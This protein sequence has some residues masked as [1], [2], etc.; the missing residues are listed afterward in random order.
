MNTSVENLDALLSGATKVGILGAGQLGKMLAHAAANW[1]LPLHFLDKQADYPAAPHAQTFTT[2]D[3]NDYEQVLAFGRDLDVITIEI[4]HVNHEALLQLEK[5]GKIIH[6]NP[7]SLGIIKDKGLQKAFYKDNGFPTSPFTLYNSAEEIRIAIM[8]KKISFPFV[9]KSRG[10]GYDGK[11]VAIIRN[12]KYLSKIIDAPSIVEPMVDIAKEIAVVAARNA[13]GEIKCYDPVEMEF[14]PE[15]NLVEFLFA[16][17]AIDA[18]VA[19]KA[20]ELARQLIEAYDI[21]G[22]LAIEFFLTPSGELLI[23]EVAPRPHNSGHHSIDAC[24]TSQF[25]QHLRGILNLPL[26]DT[27]LVSPAV[28]INLLGEKGF[29]G[30]VKYDGV[31]AIMQMEGVHLHLY[32]KKETR[33]MRKMGHATAV[34]TDLEKAK[35]LARTTQEIFKIKA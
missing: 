28:M 29:Q 7:K 1:D 33:P 9:Q 22:L 34:H 24:V 18:T 6:P 19:A 32:G 25:E 11:G 5:E 8:R 27:S 12:E 35:T 17:A 23:N 13:N 31:S 4:E 3:F 2:G 20:T 15:A 16:P 30:K 10:A 14:E 26:G 21:C